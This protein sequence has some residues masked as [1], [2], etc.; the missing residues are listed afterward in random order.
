M[1]AAVVWLAL[2]AAFPAGAQHVGYRTNYYAVTGATVR[3]IHH[4]LRESRPW[5]R[6]GGHDASTIWKVTW[7]FNTT[8]NGSVC[9]VAGFSTTASIT[10]TLPRWAAPT[11][12]ADTVKAEW[13]RY[14]K[15]LGQHEFGH[16]QFALLAAAEMQKRVKELGSDASCDSLKQRINGLCDAIVQSHKQLELAYDQRTEHGATQGARLGRNMFAPSLP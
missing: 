4:S 3:E 10:I 2:A 8:Y 9:R 7:R 1:R 14:I 12:A 16:A 5:K 13:D 11:N 6:E 15:A